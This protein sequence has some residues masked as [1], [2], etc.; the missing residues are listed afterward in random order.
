MENHYETLGLKTS[1]SLEEIRRAYRILARRYHPDLN[2][3]RPV[4]EERF[5][6]I[7]IA[8]AILSDPEKKRLYDIELERIVHQRINTA[9]EAY[10]RAQNFSKAAQ[11]LRKRD[12][13]VQYEPASQ[14]RNV[15]SHA[16]FLSVLSLKDILKPVKKIKELFSKS[17]KEK[18]P[19]P[20][21]SPHKKVS[22]IEVSISL[23]DAITGVKKTVELV[24]PEGARKIS[25]T[26]PAGTRNGSVIHLRSK[27]PHNE[28]L[29]IIIRL[30]HHPYLS[31][32]TRGL[33]FE[34]PI[35]VTEAFTGASITV[36]TFEE[37]VSIRIPPGSQ[38]GNEIRVTERGLYLKD[39]TRGDLF[40]RLLIQ[41]PSSTEAVGLK[42]QIEGVEPYYG[43]G[44]R[45]QLPKNLFEICGK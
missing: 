32:Q 5:K 28:E 3:D 14:R 13:T 30:P 26:I 6:K 34:I 21:P 29:V 41:I 25:I 22:V 19:K 33:V 20:P 45:E 27:P 12:D 16:E 1:A 15:P 11:R 2:P 17:P 31:V 24:E 7:S 9:H 38:S 36:P 4:A 44:V 18:K 35:T 43:R 8:Y 39:G 40:I 37:P 10:T 42:Q 23:R